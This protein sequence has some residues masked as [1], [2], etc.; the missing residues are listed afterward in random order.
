MAMPETVREHPVVEILTTV[1]PQ[2]VEDFQRLLPQ[3]S[4]RE[5][6]LP[7]V[8]EARLLAACDPSNQDSRVVVI[9][10]QGRIRASATG[11][12][13]RIPTGEKPWIDDV[14]TDEAYRGRGYGRQLMEALH[15]WFEERGVNSVNLT[16]NPSR[17]AAGNL[18]EDM[19]YRQLDTRV[20]RKPLGRVAVL[21]SM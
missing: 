12:I 8:L 13:C 10:D 6:P 2:D 18:Y 17:E 4:S 5:L 1:T 11:N 9:R 16:S 14:V 21:G 20:Y 3:L 19:G 7:D 15:E